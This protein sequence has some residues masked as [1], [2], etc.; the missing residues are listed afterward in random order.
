MCGSVYCHT[1]GFWSL[2]SF[3]L[4]SL[5]SQ[6]PPGSWWLRDYK[7]GSVLRFESCRTMQIA[8]CAHALSISPG[9]RLCSLITADSRF[10]KTQDR[11][12]TL[13]AC[14]SLCADKRA[15]IIGVDPSSGLCRS[16]GCLD[17][18]CVLCEHNPQR[19]CNVNFAPKYLVNDPLKA[20][21]EAP[22]RIE[23]IDR[24]TGVPVGEDIPD[25][26]LEVGPSGSHHPV[27]VSPGPSGNAGPSL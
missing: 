16:L 20:K 21:C 9:R 23:V 14:K 1:C 10:S 11:A 3:K 5:W 2:G 18:Q 26:H 8:S 27:L 24:A 22:I 15:Q 19:R 4:L 25:M 13:H 7:W 6:R 12:C 17:M